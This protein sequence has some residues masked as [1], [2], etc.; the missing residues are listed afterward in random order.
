MGGGASRTFGP[1]PWIRGIPH[2][3][4]FN[5]K[6]TINVAQD[7]AVL[8]VSIKYIHMLNGFRSRM[9]TPHF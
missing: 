1:G 7:R 8:K 6:I 5:L 3:L 9:E 4:S 2:I